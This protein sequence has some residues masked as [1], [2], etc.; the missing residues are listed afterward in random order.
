MKVQQTV[1]NRRSQYDTL[2]EA[3]KAFLQLHMLGVVSQ[4][5]DMLQEVQGKQTADGKRQIIRALGA[6]IREVGSAIQGVAPQVGDFRI[7]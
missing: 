1:E 3:V 6:F 2:D 5:N 7:S 4:L